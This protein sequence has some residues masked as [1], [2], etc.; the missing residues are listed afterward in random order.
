MRNIFNISLSEDLSRLVEKEVKKGGYSS[1]SEFFRTLL[2]RWREE[3][4]IIKDLENSRKEFRAGKGKL[5]KSLA[6]FDD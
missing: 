4:E 6:D 1:K 2:R 3:Q 5:L